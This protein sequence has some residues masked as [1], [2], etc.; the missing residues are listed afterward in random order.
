[1]VIV[2]DPIYALSGAA[3]EGF[4][5]MVGWNA[6][7]LPGKNQTGVGVPCGEPDSTCYIPDPERGGRIPESWKN[8]NVSGENVQMNG[9]GD[10]LKQGGWVGKIVNAFPGGKALSQFHDNLFNTGMLKFTP[11][12]N[13]GSMLPAAAIN[14]AAIVDQLPVDGHRCPGCYR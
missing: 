1:M 8:L 12:T 14:Y 5:E 4:R 13:W 11:L 9:D 2:S 6:D 3:A 7:P 10:Y